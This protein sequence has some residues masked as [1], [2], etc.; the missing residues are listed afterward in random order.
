MSAV[1]HRA[2]LE[3]ILRAAP[4]KGAHGSLYDVLVDY[5][6][7]HGRPFRPENEADAEEML[8]SLLDQCVIALQ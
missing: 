8:R 4:I 3:R 2:N 5:A 1:S 6:A 7:S